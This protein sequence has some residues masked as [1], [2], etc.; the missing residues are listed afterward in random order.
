[1]HEYHSHDFSYLRV[2]SVHI[3][4]S[5]DFLHHKWRRAFFFMRGHMMI[6][7][8]DYLYCSFKLIAE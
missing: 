6:R 8:T 1:M 4:Q 2:S 7:R 5:D 3:Q